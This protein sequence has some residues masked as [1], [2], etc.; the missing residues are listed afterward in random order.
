MVSGT[1]E[2]SRTLLLHTQEDLMHWLNMIACALL[3][4]LVGSLIGT[5]YALITGADMSAFENVA[6]WA[7]FIGPI[8]LV[9]I[10]AFRKLMR[11]SDVP[12]T[13]AIYHTLL[14][15]FAAP[16]LLYAAQLIAVA[17]GVS[18][19]ARV[20]EA[21]KY[22][23]IPPVF[24]VAVLYGIWR[25]IEGNR[26]RATSASGRSGGAPPPT[27]DGDSRSAPAVHRDA[28]GESSPGDGQ[29]RMIATCCSG[30]GALLRLVAR[31]A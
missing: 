23:S 15:T 29:R 9:V 5:A 13:R 1:A 14:I 10:A 19:L 18:T 22:W 8:V 30:R 27:G 7:G 24:V 28:A 21:L 25:V 20:F 17:A 6:V 4:A 12:I 31:P 16:V 2:M 11:E 3:Y 26:P